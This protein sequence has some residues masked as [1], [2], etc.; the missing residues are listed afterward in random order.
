MFI[1]GA[2][3]IIGG[4]HALQRKKWWLALVGSVA[5]FFP[6]SVLGMAAIVLTAMSKKEFE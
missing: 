4:I 5:T 6:F 2:F 3:A 1:F